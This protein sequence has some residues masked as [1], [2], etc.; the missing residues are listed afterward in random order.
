MGGPWEGTL[1]ISGS[2]RVKQSR[3]RLLRPQRQR[4]RA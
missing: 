1:R 3:K 2:G 4:E